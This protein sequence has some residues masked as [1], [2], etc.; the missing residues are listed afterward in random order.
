[1]PLIRVAVSGAP[2]TKVEGKMKAKLYQFHDNRRP[3]YWGTW[4]RRSDSVGPRKPLAKDKV[5]HHNFLTFFPNEKYQL[6]L[7]VYIY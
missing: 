5:K 3:P 2:S 7:L 6:I 4:R 1:M